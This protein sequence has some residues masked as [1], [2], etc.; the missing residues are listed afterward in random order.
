MQKYA[1]PGNVREL[2]NIIER[3]ILLRTSSEIEPLRLVGQTIL[4]PA[5]KLELSGQQE[6]ATLLDMEKQ[7]I[8]RTLKRLGGNHTQSA[9]ALGISRSTLMRKLKRYGL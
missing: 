4:E 8:T 1:W 7:H 2:R 9:N 6:V 3:A 5:E